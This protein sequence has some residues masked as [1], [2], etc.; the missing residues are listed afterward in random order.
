MMATASTSLVY[1]IFAKFHGDETKMTKY[2][3]AAKVLGVAV[4]A[5]AIKFGK[6]SVQAYVEAEQSQ[7]RLQAA[8]AKFPGLADTNISRLNN[9]NATLAKKTRFDDDATASG[10]A[11]LAQFKLTGTQIE[12]LTPL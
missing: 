2:G 1:D 8:F 11:V 10:Q 4:G 9:L 3:N 7:N 6:D 5:L 12:R